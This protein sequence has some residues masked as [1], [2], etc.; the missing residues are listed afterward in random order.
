MARQLADAGVVR[1]P[2]LFVLARTFEQL[3]D[4]FVVAIFPFYALAAAAVFV[5]RRKRPELARPMRVLGYP[6]V[7]LLFVGAS[8][9]I[10]GNALRE[11]PGATGFA[12]GVILAGVPVYWVRQ[13]ASGHATGL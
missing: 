7:P 9:L 4:Q 8:L 10:L 2:W 3:A 5:L 12:F 13:R 6:A 11:H 1:S